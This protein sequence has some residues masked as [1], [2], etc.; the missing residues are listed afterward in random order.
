MNVLRMTGDQHSQLKAHLF[1]GDGYEALAIALCGRACGAGREVWTVHQII[2]IP[3]GDCNRGADFITWST[4]VLKS[5]LPRA[6][7]NGFSILKIH[8]H[9]TGFPQFSDRDDQSDREL[10]AAI[11]QRVPGPHLSAVMLPNGEIFARVIDAPLAMAPVDRVSVVGHDLLFF[12]RQAGTVKRDF[13]QR[14]RQAF[15]DRT[16]DLLAGLTVGL[17]G[18]SGTGSP[19]AEMMAR[20]GAKRIVQIEPDVVEG[21]N[22]NRIYGS[23]RQDA[24]EARNKAKMMGDYIGR[25]G[26]GTEVTSHFGR[27]DDPVAIDLLAGCD[28]V[29]G[30]MD[31]VEG[32]DTL[33]RLATFYTLP[34]LDLGVRLDADGAG[35]VKSVSGSVHYLLPGASSLKS[36]GVYTDEQVYAEYLQ[37]TDPAFYADQVKR[38]YIR[39][40]KVDSPAVISINT[41]VA[42]FAV[43]ELLARL[44]PFRTVPNAEFAIHKLLISHGR[45]TRRPEGTVDVELAQ[46]VGR[47]DCRPLLMCGRMERA[48]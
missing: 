20:L 43:N 4:S 39:G 42:S 19:T 1:P 47:G 22:L 28:V 41:A 48:A 14:H 6:A 26:L 21:K 11:A 24:D 46:W 23:V 5:V 37:R 15:G 2:E 3:Y 7:A 45:T 36:R 10:F 35:G 16:T 30:C 8:S 29:F 17:A 40:V 34:Y 18:V 31:S 25:M 9:P 38:G 12:D 32:R 33:N 27:V 44:H 13:D